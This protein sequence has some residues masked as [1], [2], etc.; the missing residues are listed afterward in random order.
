MEHLRQERGANNVSKRK[1]GIYYI[2]VTKMLVTG[3]HVIEWTG[4]L[5]AEE[6]ENEEE[7]E[8]EKEE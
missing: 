1:L 6:E 2:N 8:E 4:I 7:G 3:I 5:W